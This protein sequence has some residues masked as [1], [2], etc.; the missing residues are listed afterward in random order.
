MYAFGFVILVLIILY[1]LVDSRVANSF[2]KR[3]AENRLSGKYKANTI[4]LE[5][6][7]IH[8]FKLLGIPESKYRQE[9]KDD[10][11]YFSAGINSQTMDLNFA[12]AIITGQIELAGG[13]ILK[14][15]EKNNNNRQVLEFFDI[16][17]NQK[18]IVNLYYSQYASTS[19][20]LTKIAFVI[21]DFGYFNGKLLDDFLNLPEE[22][23][24]AILPHCPHSREVMEKAA[25]KGHETI[26]HMPMEPLNYPKANPGENA[27]YVHD[28]P[29]E[30]KK[31]VQGYI[32]QLPLCVGANNHMGSLA[33]TDAAVMQAVLETLK[34][35][36][37]F[38][39][40]SRTNQASIAYKMAKELMVPTYE[41]T[42]FLDTP[43]ISDKTFSEKIDYLK[44]VSKSRDYILVISHCAGQVH[45]DY[46]KRF[47]ALIDEL[48][49]ELI[50]ASQLFQ[51]DLP[52]IL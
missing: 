12:N 30:I 10:A 52:A 5:S 31:K 20:K 22:I 29:R 32:K 42:F 17:Q 3:S 49:L 28:S 7:L 13:R 24:F 1:L 11:I 48:D 2:Q 51:S 33:T 14:G 23:T 19:K 34:K 9:K 16:G 38:F 37:L 47:L 8:S 40:D 41:N 25:E 21:D 36:N 4:T 6:A 43:S 27:I 45:L 26:I 18:Y 35:S 46:L 50:P 44:T 39:I 15:V